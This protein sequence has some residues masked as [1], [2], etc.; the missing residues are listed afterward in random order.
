M[1]NFIKP[2]EMA[3]RLDEVRKRRSIAMDWSG[4]ENTLVDILNSISMSERE[5]IDMIREAIDAY[6]K[7]GHFIRTTELG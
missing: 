2:E 5:Q 6:T 4:L 1:K 7:R 3:K